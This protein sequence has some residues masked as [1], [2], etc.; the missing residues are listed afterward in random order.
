VHL[1]QVFDPFA[2]ITEGDDFASPRKASTEGFGIKTPAEG[3][4]DSMAPRSWSNPSPGPDIPWHRCGLVK[5]QPS[6]AS[7]VLADPSACLPL[8][9]WS[10]S[11]IIGSRFHLHRCRAQ[12]CRIGTIWTRPLQDA[13]LFL[14][15]PSFDLLADP[16]GYP[17][18]SF[19]LTSMRHRAQIWHPS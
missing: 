16:F 12:E 19:A 7:R 11:G 14:L 1:D 8:R 13:L 3:S 9:P 6:L 5:T 15:I 18:K 10:S 17:F 2:A 4:A